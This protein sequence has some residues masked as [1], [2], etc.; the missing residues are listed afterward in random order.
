MFSRNSDDS[1]NSNV[2]P[3]S[4]DSSSSS[5]TSEDISCVE[6]TA[7]NTTSDITNTPVIN[8]SVVNTSTT[9]VRRVNPDQFNEYDEF[10]QLVYFNV[11]G[12]D[13]FDDEMSSEISFFNFKFKYF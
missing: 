13:G 7:T 6:S 1:E 2:F 11:D 9:P 12:G 8:T 10:G 3:R 5:N 4:S